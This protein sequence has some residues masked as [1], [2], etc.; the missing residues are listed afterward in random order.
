MTEIIAII[1]GGLAIVTYFLRWVINPNSNQDT[2]IELLKSE[3]SHIKTDIH[4]IKI[5][6]LN[7]IEN[8]IK[9]LKEG[10]VRIETLLNK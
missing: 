10:Q 8:D 1:L 9:A 5:N 7:H 2:E 3:M 6:H 4:D